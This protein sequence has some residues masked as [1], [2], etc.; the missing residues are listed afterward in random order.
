MQEAGPWPGMIRRALGRGDTEC[1]QGPGGAQGN[2]GV[3]SFPLKP[4]PQPP[5][6]LQCRGPA[7]LSTPSSGNGSSQTLFSG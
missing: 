6:A 2:P 5:E 3:G 7:S 4:S 1:H